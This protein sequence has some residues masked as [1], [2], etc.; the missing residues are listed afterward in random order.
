[1]GWRLPHLEG[2]QACVCTEA[3]FCASSPKRIVSMSPRGGGWWRAVTSPS[4]RPFAA[5]LCPTALAVTIA[6]VTVRN[7]KGGYMARQRFVHPS[8]WTDRNFGTLKLEERVLF[9]ALFSNADDDGR[10][11]ADPGV[12][13]GQAF[14]F[15]DFTLRK[16]RGI[17]DSL[18]GKMANVVLYTNGDSE[19][20]ALLKWDDYQKPQYRKP[21]KLPSPFHESSMRLHGKLHEASHRGLGLGL[22]RDGMGG[23]VRA[24]GQPSAAPP[25]QPPTQSHQENVHNVVT[26]KFGGAA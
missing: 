17:R 3:S 2:R 15:D 22:D 7:W 5:R 25:E 13:R 26:A 10:L 14:A 19:Y 24:E 8:M 6:I 12:L 11:V 1:V 9:V 20:I 21:S 18:A 16:V 4:S 23:A